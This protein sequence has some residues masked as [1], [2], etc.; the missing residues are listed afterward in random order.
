MTFHV[1][2]SDRLEGSEN[3]NGCLSNL[4]LSPWSFKAFVPK[5]AFLEPA[6][7]V[8]RFTPGHDWRI[9]SSVNA[10]ESIY[11]GFQFSAEMD[12][13]SITDAISIKST[14]YG[15]NNA[16]IDKSTVFCSTVDE[17]QTASWP[18]ALTSVYNYSVQV[19]NVFHGVHEIIVNNASSKNGKRATNVSYMRYGMATELTDILVYRSLYIS[20]RV[21]G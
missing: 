6:P 19:T 8:T 21:H 2:D 12:C 16:L 5:E 15:G 9:L 13:N 7:F 4:T 10:G 20:H 17:T 3:W 14:T 18:G 11:I 1:A